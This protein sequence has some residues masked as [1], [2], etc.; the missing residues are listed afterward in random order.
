MK[1]DAPKPR[2]SPPK[3]TCSSLFQL[4]CSKTTILELLKNSWFLLDFHLIISQHLALK[5]DKNSNKVQ[6]LSKLSKKTTN[7]KNINISLY[8][9][10]F[11]LQ[12]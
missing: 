10:E 12:H 1:N 5:N 8:R 2:N 7:I 11:H 4:T 6:D 3:I 9:V